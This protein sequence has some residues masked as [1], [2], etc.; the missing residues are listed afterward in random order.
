M[1]RG[2]QYSPEIGTSNV[3]FRLSG[4]EVLRERGGAQMTQQGRPLERALRNNVNEHVF[5]GGTHRQ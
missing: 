3:I 5:G 1:G 2:V 4:K